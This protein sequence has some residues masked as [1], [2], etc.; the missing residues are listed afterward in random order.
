[1]QVAINSLDLLLSLTHHDEN[2]LQ[3][4]RPDLVSTLLT[5]ISHSPPSC[6]IR[7]ERLAR[8]LKRL[9]RYRYNLEPLYAM[10]FHFMLA[11][12]L[13]WRECLRRRRRAGGG[14]CR[15]CAERK[16]LGREVFTEFAS[17]MDSEFGWSL[18]QLRLQRA[19]QTG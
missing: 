4:V 6:P 5:F 15:R 14:W 1:L 12:R 2:Y 13:V 10:D 11:E 16:E 8:S 9:A 18:I 19:E 7:L 3:L 17:L